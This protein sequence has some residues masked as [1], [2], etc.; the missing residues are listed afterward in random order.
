M[1]LNNFDHWYKQHIRNN[2]T[3]R[4]RLERKKKK[5]GLNEDKLKYQKQC[6]YVNFLVDEG[7]SEFLKLEVLES[8]NDVKS[9]FNTAKRILNWQ[10]QPIYPQ[11]IEECK[12]AQSFADFFY[13]KII[14]ISNS[15]SDNIVKEAIHWDCDGIQNAAARIKLAFIEIIRISCVIKCIFKDSLGCFLK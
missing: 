1:K 4:R 14:R 8:K 13:D 12:I 7:K 5:T 2:K 15:I 11:N 3:L 6:K 10:N 9:L